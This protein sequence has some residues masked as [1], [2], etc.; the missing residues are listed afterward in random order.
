MKR[1]IYLLIG[2][3]LCGAALSALMLA[4]HY[5][6]ALHGKI[7]A[8]GGGLADPC[9][10]VNQSEYAVFLG[11]PVAAYGLY[12]Y[13]FV[14]FTL[15]I[16]DYAAGRYYYFC[17]GL[18]FPLIA[19]ALAA[20]AVLGALLVY[21]GAMCTICVATYAIN[22]LMLIVLL[23]WLREIRR[24]DSFG[25]RDIYR[26]MTTIGAADSDIR[27]VYS[28]FV[29]FSFL[30]LFTVFSTSTILQLKT[31]TMK[32][33]PSQVRAHV[34][35]IYS[36]AA[37]T[38]ALPESMLT[39][40]PADAPVTMVVF[41]DFLCSACRELF[42]AERSLLARY[43]RSLRIAYYNFPLDKSCNA[44]AG[45]TRY[46]GSCWA[47]KA[48]IASGGMGL[49][50]EYLP[51][52]FSAYGGIAHHYSPEAAVAVASR[53][54]DAESFRNEMNSAATEDVLRRD[55]D[56]A[57]KYGVQATPTLFING[58]R[59]EGVPPVEILYGVID[60]ELGKEK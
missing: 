50:R 29:V 49:F 59:I 32:L 25:L 46:A 58:R 35:G 14:V 48:F 54:G 13:L 11:I 34:N 16:G 45:K 17:A 60:R 52:H 2:L 44:Y 27:A 24:R 33:A 28:T 47:S 37:E 20:D 26:M 30:L 39:L 4:G 18:L 43:P 36:Q 5:F 40:G 41:S 10:T 8:C 1:F 15:L 21:I 57:Q 22:V 23:F 7:I 12:F 53:L 55:M 31:G 38:M 51:A 56:L 3:S 19:L 9:F 6:P 42:V